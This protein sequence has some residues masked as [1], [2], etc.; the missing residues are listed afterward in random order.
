MLDQVNFLGQDLR[1]PEC[2]LTNSQG[3][4]FT[5]NWDGGVSIIES[6][7]QQWS[8]L[9]KAGSHEIKPNGI[10]LLENGDFLLAHLG[11]DDGGV[12]RLQ[13]DGTLTPFL[14]EVDGQP[15]PPT[16]YVHIDFQGRIW[17]TVS[18]R[19]KPRADAYRSNISDGF[20]VLY[21]NGKG[22]IV[23]DNLG[24]TNECIASPDGKFLYVNE[25]FA[26]RLSR[27]DITDDGNL[28]NQTTIATFGAGIFPDGLVFDADENFWITS[29]VSN[30]VIRVAKDGSSQETM[31]IDVDKQ[32]LAW[33]E[34]AFQNH[35]MG[36]PHLDNVKSDL[37]QNVSSLAFGGT[38]LNTLY[39]GCLLGQQIA[40]VN[41]S[42]KGLAPSHWHFK[43][44]Q[45]P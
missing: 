26:R 7:G 11:N 5:S 34:E 21:E 29:I 1:R 22:S 23:A 6:D 24:Y 17:I 8:I 32:H 38:T 9:A 16:N 13:A 12:Y 31:L 19:T 18:T 41:Q 20:I 25:T 2:V 15:L 30:Q 43:G 45:R 44:P 10:C 35:S 40:S 27:F 36:R 42:V 37:L 14:L 4:I 33:V 3:R 39:L 28:T